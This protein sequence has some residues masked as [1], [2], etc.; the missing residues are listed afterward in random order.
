M[1]S[2][3]SWSSNR[4]A[5]VEH[6]I[7]NAIFPPA[8]ALPPLLLAALPPLLGAETASVEE[9]PL[10][11]PASASAS[12]AADAPTIACILFIER[13]CVIGRDRSSGTSTGTGP[14]T[15]T[16]TRDASKRKRGNRLRYSL[17]TASGTGPGSVMRDS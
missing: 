3:L 14:G 16:V 7:R 6:G 11:H 1:K 12:T 5:H 15:M 17:V 2:G 10:L 13:S 9:P 8:A 4:A